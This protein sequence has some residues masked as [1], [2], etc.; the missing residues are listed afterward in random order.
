MRPAKGGSLHRDDV[1]V[2]HQ[3]DRLEGRV[4]PLPLVQQAVLARHLAL[5]AGVEPRE[6]RPQIVVEPGELGAIELGR[7]RVRD[8]A[9]LERPGE[10]LSRRRGVEHESCRRL[11]GELAGRE[12]RGAIQENGNEEQQSQAEADD[13]SLHSPH[14]PT[15]A[16]IGD[17]RKAEGF[18]RPRP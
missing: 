1:L 9:E 12:S 6:S 13:G 15:L 3:Q 11:G 5:Q 10:P 7:V 17:S 8:G 2:R 4:G 14:G 16:R 18:S